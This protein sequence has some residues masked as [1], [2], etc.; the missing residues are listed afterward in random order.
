MVE[1]FRYHETNFDG[2]FTFSVPMLGDRRGGF[3]KYFSNLSRELLDDFVIGEI[4]ATTSKQ[5]VIRGMHFQLPPLPQSKYLF[6][7]SG[8]VLEVVID[9][10]TDSETYGET[11]STRMEASPVGG[12]S[13]NPTGIF[14]PSGFAHGYLVASEHATVVYCADFDFDPQLD[15]GVAWDSIDFEWPI[16]DPIISDKDLVLPKLKDFSSPFVKKV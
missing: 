9:L 8:E 13:S 12:I 7:L 2:V 10:R 15:A 4:F 6:V 11:Y 5:D 1:M 14:V 3:T 16:N